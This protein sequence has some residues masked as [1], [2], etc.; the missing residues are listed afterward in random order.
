MALFETDITQ[1]QTRDRLLLAALTCFS[2]KGYHQTTTDEIVAESGLGKGTLYRYFENKQDLFISMV[3][4]AMDMF[5]REAVASLRDDMSAADKIRAMVQTFLTE[6][7]Q[8]V[9]FFKVTLDFWAQTLDS[10]RLQQTFW[11]YL[12][13]YGH[14]LEEIINAGIAAGE[15]RPVNAWHVALSIVGLLDALG[16]YKTLL[17]DEIEMHGTVTTAVD[18]ILAGISVEAAP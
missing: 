18:A 7:E 5:D 17:S 10:S 9:P 1:L 15:F 8:L 12:Q 2:R 3:G 16:L 11:K 6:S 4:W 13:R 14:E